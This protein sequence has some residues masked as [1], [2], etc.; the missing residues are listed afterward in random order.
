[1]HTGEDDGE[2]PAKV[3]VSLLK[4]DRA[5]EEGDNDHNVSLKPSHAERIASGRSVSRESSID[6]RPVL[7]P[8]LSRRISNDMA[9][10]VS[11]SPASVSRLGSKGSGVGLRQARPS[12]G[13]FS[14]RHRYL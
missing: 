13:R 7:T 5:D 11:H 3:F 12:I 1:M 6:P 14:Y 8:A 2:D 4:H 10:G 9:M